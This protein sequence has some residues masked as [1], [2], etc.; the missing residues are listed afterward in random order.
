MATVFTVVGEHRADPARL[1]LRGE[2]GR[3]YAYGPGGWPRAVEPTGAWVFDADP[4][5]TANA[6]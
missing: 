5:T 6:A 4:A 1:L 3:Y 2:D